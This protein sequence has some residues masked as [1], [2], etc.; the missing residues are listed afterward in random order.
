MAGLLFSKKKCLEV[1]LE[2]GFLSYKKGKVIP[3]RWAED[4]SPCLT[5]VNRVGHLGYTQS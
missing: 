2:G 5:C 3:A 4:R 1:S